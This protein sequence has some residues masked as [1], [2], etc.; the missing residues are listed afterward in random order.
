MDDDHLVLLLVKSFDFII[1]EVLNAVLRVFR[2][3]SKVDV[4]TGQ[5]ILTWPTFVNIDI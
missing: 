3:E 2:R 5:A 4:A 1:K